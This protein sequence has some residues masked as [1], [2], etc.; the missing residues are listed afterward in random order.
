[1]GALGCRMGDGEIH[2]RL[3]NDAIGTTG[4]ELRMAMSN[5]Q[6]PIP[7]IDANF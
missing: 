5:C 1:M 3:A 7:K 4:A 2:R 6:R